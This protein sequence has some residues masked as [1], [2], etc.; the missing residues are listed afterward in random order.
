MQVAELK[1][2]VPYGPL[3]SYP[4]DVQNTSYIPGPAFVS[5]AYSRVSC[6]TKNPAVNDEFKIR[7]PDVLSANH[8]H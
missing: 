1:N 7:L 5:E 3:F 2:E 6:H 4:H 8:G